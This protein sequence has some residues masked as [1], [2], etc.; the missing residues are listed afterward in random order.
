MDR[1][2]H[3]VDGAKGDAVEGALQGLCAGGVDGEGEIENAGGFFQKGGLFALRFGEGHGDLGA[4]NGDGDSG[5]TG[6][7]AEVEEG[8]DAGGEGAGAGDGFDEMAGENA[9]FVADCG[10]I[11]AGIPAKNKRN[12]RRKLFRFINLSGSDVPRPATD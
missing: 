5:K 9:V 10:E 11:D 6:A 2:G 8:G 7:G 3:A 1:G 12:I 4:A